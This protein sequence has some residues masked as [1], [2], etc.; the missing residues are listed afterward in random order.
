[1]T[2]DMVLGDDGCFAAKFKG[3]EPRPAQVKLALAI[4]DALN[5][6]Q[7]LLAEAPCG[8]GKSVAYCIPAIETALAT[9]CKVA[10]VTANITL[11]EQ[12]VYKDLPAIAEILPV[13]FSWALL[14]GRNNYLCVE[15]ILGT[16]L[17]SGLSAFQEADLDKVLAWADSTL[18]GDISD[19]DF[20]PSS[21]VW[22][23]VSCGAEECQ[24]SKCPS[25]DNCFSNK[26]RT[27]ANTANIIVTNYHLLFSHCVVADST[28]RN[29]IVLPAF[30]Y[31]IMDEAHEAA[32]IARDFFGFSISEATFVRLASALEKLGAVNEGHQLRNA[33]RHFFGSMAGARAGKAVLRLRQPESLPSIAPLEATLD[34]AFKAFEQIVKEGGRDGEKASVYLPQTVH[35][36]ARLAEIQGVSDPAKVYWAELA[37]SKV[38]LEA[39]FVKVSAV[40]PE[41]LFDGL[42]ATVAISATLTT[43]GGF[44]FIRS[45]LGF[46]EDCRE[47]VV[48]SP[49]DYLKQCLMIVPYEMPSTPKDEQFM[50]S[51]A[52][53]FWQ[54]TRLNV[55][56]LGLFTSYR[57]LDQVYGLLKDHLPEG[58]T[59]IKQGDGPKRE[60]IKRFAEDTQSVL[61][62][63]DSY[64][65]G[66]DVPGDACG[67]VVIDK[68]PF[69]TPDDPVL[70]ALSEGLK[71]PF[72]EQVLPRAIIK[73]RQGVGR[74]IRTRTDV[75]AVVILDRRVLTQ[76]YGDWFIRSLPRMNCSQHTT[77]APRFLEWARAIRDESS[78]T[79]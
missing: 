7:D 24:G 4:E 46:D 43:A 11:Q 13:T 69:P 6:G 21:S 17:A 37:D 22:G 51:A 31:L 49:F 36:S 14:K 5:Q 47:L 3:Y 41:L 62:G 77:D 12:I 65:T 19:L 8:T 23:L 58:V 39:R 74:L 20:V 45:E 57:A 67:V 34:A 59:F 16:K 15:K 60:L 79:S 50:L 40:L 52:R 26:A 27:K 71:N 64:W 42:K 32:N 56:V 73:L 30:D 9:D 35:C 70:E 38:T 48:D 1:M 72:K 54:I 53:V 2:V 66:V 61:F 33:A 75:G 10:I 68:L 28:G 25:K 76:W 63:V 29:D 44:G 55:G 18:T 78:R